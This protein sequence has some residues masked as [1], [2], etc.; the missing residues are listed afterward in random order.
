MR[1][2]FVKIIFISTIMFS[3]PL[4]AGELTIPNSFTA[5]TPALAEEVNS[6]F[7]AVATEV[8]D[9]NIRV[10][11]NK[12]NIDTNDSNISI[13]KGLISDNASRI[14]DNV[15]AMANMLT[16]DGSGNLEIKGQ[17][18]FSP[19]HTSF[20]QILPTDF[21]PGTSGASSPHLVGRDWFNGVFKLQTE[22]NVVYAGVKLPHGSKI[23]KFSCVFDD[24]DAGGDPEVVLFRQAWSGGIQEAITTINTS[25]AE[26]A[27]STEYSGVLDE[28]L[29]SIDLD[30]YFYY[31]YGT[32]G[33]IDGG[34]V[35]IR[36]C[37]IVFSRDHI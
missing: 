19:P 16:H 24:T 33:N 14:D 29:T 28:A 36:R 4:Q 9:N 3:T 21:H 31:A 23:A 25:G 1:R 37:K 26:D 10:S 35:M 11:S 34:A 18:S 17:L 13:N 2:L 20:Y 15:A 22:T 32:F 12:T 30:R 5:G 27:I 6:N 7:K 8:N